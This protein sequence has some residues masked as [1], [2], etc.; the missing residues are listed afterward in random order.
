MPLRPGATVAP[1]S[2]RY[3]YSRWDGTQRGFELDEDDVLAAITDD[4]IE[5][6]DVNAALRR[7]LNDG[8]RAANGD[9]IAGL[10]E[11]LQRLR[12]A[13][14]QRLDQFD[15]GGV[16]DEISRELADIVD[17]ERHAVD[18]AEIA[19]RDA[20]ERHGD[21]G[22][23]DEAAR[24]AEDRRLDL[25]LLPDDL[26]G[27]V[28]ALQRHEFLSSEAQR[29]FDALVERLRSR[30]ATQAFE[31]MSGSMQ[32]L[33]PQSQQRLKEMLTDLNEMLARHRRGD[34]PRFDEFMARHGDFFPEQPRTI[35]ELL[36]ALARRAAAMQALLGSMTP[37]QR[38]E[39]FRLSEALLDDIGL[40]EQISELG[41]QLR[42][43][44][45]GGGWDAAYEFSG[46][47]ALGLG[48]ALDTMAELGDLDRLESL[49]RGVTSPAALAE[50]D[51]ER[52]GELLGDDAMRSLQRLAELTRL[53]ADAGLIENTEAGLRL[54]PR[55][56]RQIGENALREVFQRLTKDQI[57]Q[58]QTV[59]TGYGHE[60]TPDSKRYE[61]GD[62][63]RLDLQRTIRNAL[64]R[65]AT[66]DHGPRSGV[67]VELVPDDFEIELTEHLTRS[68]TVLMLDLS[69]SMPMEGRFV[70]AKKVAMALQ[71]L[72]A[73][74]FPRDYLGV[75]VFSET[76]RVIRAAEIPEAS[77]DY[78]YGTNMHHALTLAR[79]L[80]SRQHGSKQIIMVTDGEPTAHVLPDG[81]VY[82][83]YPPVRETIEATLREVVRCTTAG[84][85]IN[86]FMLGATQSLKAFVERISEINRGRAFFATPENLGDYVLVDF[87]EHRRT[88]SRARRP[89]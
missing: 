80:L 17:E 35:D 12:E 41:E 61:F 62:P 51:T 67:P 11:L 57:G 56:V 34:D 37:E 49:L 54:T 28:A 10:R 1:V 38:D 63:F 89:G 6:G 25:D 64:V 24:V 58:H 60:R 59:R 3:T 26:A 52:V 30:L 87:I 73:S 42:A 16:Y 78:V 7:L 82:F 84:I 68:S 21:T 19:D 48:T 23:A 32:T 74:Q 40:R 76:A 47:D 46:T 4:L 79:Q 29:R 88:L 18:L 5:H 2:V 71:A 72:I 50:V 44:V 65:R 31:Q 33:T 55:G 45:P 20:A 27:K 43:L 9:S 83:H 81:E 69:M 70:P 22:L 13:R 86:T 15:L 39:L 85:R 53:L 36:E 66:D 14:R 77:W 75:V 8:L